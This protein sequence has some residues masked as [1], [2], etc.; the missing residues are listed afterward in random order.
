[1]FFFLSSS[2]FS[3]NS[4][5]FLFSKN[6]GFH[7]LTIYLKPNNYII[8][9]IIVITIIVIIIKIVMLINIIVIVTL[10]KSRGE[11]L[12]ARNSRGLI[13]RYSLR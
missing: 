3:F 2:C 7:L 1:M 8:T 13:Y 12:Q 4:S 10:E 9:I 6:F 5:N 11:D